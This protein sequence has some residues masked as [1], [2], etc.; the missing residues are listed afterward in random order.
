MFYFFIH[1]SVGWILVIVSLSV[2]WPVAMLAYKSVNKLRLFMLNKIIS[3][4]PCGDK[5]NL[6][7]LNKL[8]RAQ[9]ASCSNNSDKGSDGSGA[10]Y[11]IMLDTNDTDGRKG[12]WSQDEGSALSSLSG[13]DR[14]Q[15]V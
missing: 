15:I 11:V 10:E 8:P 14:H 12:I 4:E 7:G 2:M 13:G 1:S 5:T 3:F 9:L 6:Y